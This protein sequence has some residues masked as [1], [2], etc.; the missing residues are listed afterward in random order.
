MHKED[1]GWTISNKKDPMFGIK[2]LDKFFKSIFGY[3]NWHLFDMHYL[4]HNV[5]LVL[6]P[7]AIS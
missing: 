7:I 2:C 6:R 4:E 1:L 3:F 5:V